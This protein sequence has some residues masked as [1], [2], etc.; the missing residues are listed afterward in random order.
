MT[1]TPGRGIRHQMQRWAAAAA[2][3]ALVV[4]GLT[5]TEELL[6]PPAPAFAGTDGYGFRG[7]SGAGSGWLGS[8]NTPGGQGFCIDPAGVYPSGT[9]SYV[10][11]VAFIQGTTSSTWPNHNDTRSMSGTDLQRLNYAL[12][13]YTPGVDTNVEGAGLAA[14]VYS[15]SMAGN[16]GA[17]GITDVYD[18]IRV[19]VPSASRA[20]VTAQYEA[21]AADTNANYALGGAG[22]VNVDLEMQSSYNGTVTVS[23]SP[24][25][26]SGVVTL[27][28]GTFANGSA[29]ATVVNGSVLDVTGTPLDSDIQKYAISALLT[30]V[31]QGAPLQQVSLWTTS[32]PSYAQRL[33]TTSGRG[34]GATLTDF[35]EVDDPE[36]LFSPVLSTEVESR[37]VAAGDTYVDTVSAGVAAGSEDWRQL[38]DGSYIP[39]IARGTLYGPFTDTPVEVADVPVGAPVLGTASVTLTGPGTYTV[40]GTIVATESGYATWVW[41][42]TAADQPLIFRDRLPDDYSFTDLFGR[43]AET[44]VVAMSVSASTAANAPQVAITED[45]WDTLEVSVSGDWLTIEGEPVPVAFSGTAY[46]EAGSTLPVA[47]AAPPATATVLGTRS[48]TVT[49][50]GSYSTSG[51][52][53]TAPTADGYVVWQ[54]SIVE[55]A[56]PVP[57][58]GYVVDW[59]DT[60]GL[61]A[62]TTRVQAPTVATQA[63]ADVALTDPAYDLA[64]VDG[65]VPDG[66]YL[67]FEAYQQPE[68]GDPVL[69]A[70]G[71]PVLDVD[72]EPVLYGAG[73]VGVPLCTPATLVFDSSG[74]PVAVTAGANSATAYQSPSFVPLVARSFF[75]IE[76]LHL[77]AGA[78]QA[79]GVCGASGETTRVGVSEVST[80]A[81][82]IVLSGGKARDTAMVDGLVPVDASLVF[83]AYLHGDEDMAAGERGELLCDTSS[84]P[85]AVTPGSNAAAVYESPECDMPSGPVDVYW[86]E[87]LLG[88]GGEILHEGEYGTASEITSVSP[89]LPHLSGGDNASWQLVGGAGAV[90]LGILAVAWG[91]WRRRRTP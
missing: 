48:L 86:V 55:A 58:Q 40:P 67:T 73:D 8:I 16:L 11:S 6:T 31:A 32:S 30:V 12:A 71:D 24:T 78:V 2:A 52:P 14:F 9:T 13:K 25:N 34:T 74:S 43:A 28:G 33:I 47:G 61:S 75:W 7:G 83:F 15:V 5:I 88:S 41:T 72:G 81:A 39:I 89:R 22:T 62:E 90:A 80:V 50:P 23:I 49:E 56:Q 70:A 38:T 35:D 87:Q 20:A 29:T 57:L 51:D 60:Y 85:V 84:S 4:V 64:L 66:A 63:L 42:I 1:T 17:Y 44:H 79:R 82:A 36:I 91:V 10:G 18:Y 65:L 76:T 46:W 37:F 45:L 59:S 54:W 27:S 19:R 77:Q 68:E 53:I 21:I 26:L 69:D 3:L